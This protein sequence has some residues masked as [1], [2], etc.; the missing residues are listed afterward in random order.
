MLC[1]VQLHV[2]AESLEASGKEQEVI[3]GTGK[4]Y[5]IIHAKEGGKVTGENLTVTENKDTNSSS[6][7][8]VYVIT[9]ESKGC[10]QRLCN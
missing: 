10:A 7:T 2:H 4:A 3:G 1:N 9:T 6:N 5:E 8:N